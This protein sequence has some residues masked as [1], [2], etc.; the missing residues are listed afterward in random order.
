MTHRAK[1]WYL[2]HTCGASFPRI[3]GRNQAVWDWLKQTLG[4]S[5]DQLYR[6]G[7]RVVEHE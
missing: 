2:A 3:S 5:R 6:R 7:W 1:S 4:R